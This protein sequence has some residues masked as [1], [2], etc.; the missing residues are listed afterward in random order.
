MKPYIHP[1]VTYRAMDLNERLTCAPAS[2]LIDY[3]IMA[4]MMNDKSNSIN[5]LK[6]PKVLHD[7]LAK[8]NP[9]S[10]HPVMVKAEE[11]AGITLYC[12]NGCYICVAEDKNCPDTETFELPPECNFRIVWQEFKQNY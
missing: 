8:E 10:V 4:A 12:Y 7:Q 1:V 11:F 5:F 3:S 9:G 2:R 6:M